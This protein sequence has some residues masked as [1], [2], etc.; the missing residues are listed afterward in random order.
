[1]EFEVP[2]G[3]PVIVACARS[4]KALTLSVFLWVTARAVYAVVPNLS[5]PTSREATD[6]MMILVTNASADQK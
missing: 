6:I 2:I 3:I 5:K 1:L 4:I